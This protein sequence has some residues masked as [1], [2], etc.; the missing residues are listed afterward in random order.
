MLT[1][2]SLKT[3]LYLILGALGIQLLIAVTLVLLQT[4]HEDKEEIAEHFSNLETVFLQILSLEMEAV[5]TVDTRRQLPS[6]W[7]ELLEILELP[8]IKLAKEMAQVR[9]AQSDKLYL[10]TDER[11]RLYTTLNSS[12]PNLA[13]S[14]TYIHSHH[15]AYLDNMLHKG[16]HDPHARADNNFTKDDDRPASELDIIGAAIEIQNNVLTII[17]I[18]SRLQR[19]MSPSKIEGDFQQAM[20][21]LYDSTSAFEEYSLDAQD[22]LL[23]EELLENGRSF[24]Q[25]FTRLL[26]LERERTE[27]ITALAN[28][29]SRFLA[30]LAEQRS[31]ARTRYE[32]FNTLL[33]RVNVISAVTS[34][35]I[36]IILL[37]LSRRVIKAITTAIRETDIIRENPTYRIALKSNQFFEFNFLFSALNSLAENVTKKL[38]ELEEVQKGLEQQV[39]LR[40]RELGRINMHLRQE[41]E[42]RSRQEHERK[43]LEERL[44]RAEKM[45]ALGTL[46]GGVAHDLNNI[47]SGMVSFPEILL[48]DISEDHHLR[49]P[50]EVIK[51]SG[52]KAAVIV[53]DLLTMARRGV[54]KHEIIDLNQLVVAFWESPEYLRIREHHKDVV[55]TCVLTT[56]MRTIK[57]SPVHITKSLT[58]LVTN[59]AEAIAG[60]GRLAIST[61]TCYVDTAFKRY[62]QVQ[63]GEYIRLRVRDSGSGIAPENLDKIFEPFYTTKTMGR[64]GSGLGMAVVWGTV[65]DHGGYLDVTSTMEEG[66][67]FD[68]YFPLIRTEEIFAQGESADIDL[69]GNG[70]TALIVDDVEEQRQIASMML[71]RL[72]YSVA[73]VA[74]GEEALDYLAANKVDI[75]LLDMIMQP[76]IDGLETYRRIIARYPDQKAIIVSGYSES[77]KVREAQKLGTGGYV[78]KPYSIREMA[79]AM[80]AELAG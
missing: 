76:G 78:K 23:V 21:D 44:T 53:E 70:E 51:D 8:D 10:L 77:D 46:A 22:G 66:S 45:E 32:A 9:I 18:F 13:A 11:E 33:K 58:N 4:V 47:L 16:S 20:E 42:E 71:S 34:F 62:D 57:G 72:G 28:N 41:I 7:Q 3:F 38:A 1:V 30:D 67:I 65:K 15:L 6:H 54:A 59:G 37:L 26:A 69:Q 64:S 50:L 19:G 56:T 73:A 25:S 35:L 75:L 40:T 36:V 80:K 29:S 61:S 39:E 27:T 43:A 49:K 60:K 31:L 55:Y 14:V 2:R 24:Q 63:E 12:L 74:S 79:K 68:L 17:E 52:A 5:N 48:M